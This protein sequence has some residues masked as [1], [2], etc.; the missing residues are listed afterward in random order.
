VID[1]ENYP[2]IAAV[3][4]PAD[5]EE[6]L[7][8]ELE[9]VFLLATDIM[10]LDGCIARAHEKG[11]RIFVHID[12]VEGLSKDA[13]GVAYVATKGA[14]GLISTRSNLIAVAREH[15]MM[16]VQRFFMVDSRSLHTA[17]DAVRQTRPDLVE[18]MPGVAYKAIAKMRASVG[19]PIIA[20][21][22]I[23]TKEEIY[24]AMNA[25]ACVVSTGAQSLWNM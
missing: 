8:A 16:T 7:S 1:Y 13:A 20:G 18:I 2:I 25:G 23:D 21:G 5:L 14:D 19:I 24:A 9:T 15:G 22:L 4:T 12:F 6:A 17:M 3:R 10:S 11:K